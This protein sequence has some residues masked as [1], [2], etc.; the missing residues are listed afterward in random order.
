M[1]FGR[2]EMQYDAV[3]TWGRALGSLSLLL[4]LCLPLGGCAGESVD[5]GEGEAGTPLEGVWVG[6]LASDAFVTSPKKLQLN[7]DAH[8]NG[9]LLVGETALEP[10]A[11]KAVGYPPEAQADA[12]EASSLLLHLYEGVS[13]ALENVSFSGNNLHFELTPHLA[14]EPWCALQTPVA[15][16][17]GGYRCLENEGGQIERE[18]GQKRCFADPLGD[19]QEVDCLAL[20]LCSVSHSVG[21]FCDETTCHAEMPSGRLAMSFDLELDESRTALR[22]RHLFGEEE[23]WPAPEVE[24][25]RREE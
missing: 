17:I 15:W 2:H 3:L 8:G 19:R 7:L 13:Y 22:G 4:P 24:L 9:S 14:F 6:S 16:D 18:D 12:G 23:P 5:L 10:P 11:D 1:D 21:C 25:L 20:F